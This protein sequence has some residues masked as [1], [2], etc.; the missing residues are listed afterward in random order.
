MINPSAR[1][2]KNSFDKNI[3]RSRCA[4]G[5]TL[6][7]LLVVI[8]IIGLLSSVVL[9]S[10][11]G[12]R[13][14]ASDSVRLS[15]L[16]TLQTAL[17]LYATDHSGSYPTTGGSW[18]GHCPGYGSDANYIP[19]LAPT[20]IPALPYD[21]DGSISSDNCCYLYNSNG[22]GY[23][24]VAHSCDRANYQSRPSIL[25]PARDGGSSATVV[26]PGKAA[27]AWGIYTSDYA[28]I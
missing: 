19:G 18:K 13:S 12:A 9:A 21:P 17:E 24:V 5:F 7:E 6:I 27:W 26:E 20:Y 16:R 14:K 10:L 8:A 1:L 23:K 2:S 3:N 15:D 4:R 28:G 11:N 22:A 25:D